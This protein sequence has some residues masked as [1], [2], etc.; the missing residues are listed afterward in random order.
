ME[1]GMISR[2][3]PEGLIAAADDPF[4]TSY[5]NNMSITSPNFTFHPG[6]KVGV[7]AD[8]SW[9]H[10]SAYAEYT[11]FHGSI[12][13]GVRPLPRST[14]T[15]GRPNGQYLY[16]IQ[17]TPGAFDDLFFK[18][19]SQSWT[20]KMDFLDVSLARDYYMGTK[21]TIR[22]F[23]GARGAWIRQ[24]LTT[25]Y[26]GS[27]L[28]TASDGFHNAK[29]SNQFA[30]WGVGPRL[31]LES[32]WMLGYGAR[33]IGDASVDILYTRYSIHFNQQVAQFAGI[34]PATN[35]ISSNASVSQEIDLLRTHLD[36]EMGL[37]W[38]MYLW[39][40]SYHIDLSATYGF[41]VFWDQNMCRN[42]TDDVMQAKSNI[43]NG[44]LYIHGLTANARFDF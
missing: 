19:G 32:N 3:D 36:I 16:S 11:W 17:G 39:D 10:W 9:D 5:V 14:A 8:L 30:S 20:L 29:V 24:Y 31:G 18:N 43:P 27:S 1:I 15:T 7:G 12:G 28:Y 38:G 13:T 44:N 6:F 22:P 23:F 34:G 2:N 41:Q 4:E 40:Q 33:F 35:P 26:A 21:F 42:F 37:G 25:S